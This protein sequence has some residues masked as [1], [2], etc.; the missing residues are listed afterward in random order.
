MICQSPKPFT[1]FPERGEGGEEKEPREESW[2]CLCQREEKN[3]ANALASPL[4]PANGRR[5]FGDNTLNA[6]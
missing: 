5:L 4:A 3:A 2:I 1:R 6:N